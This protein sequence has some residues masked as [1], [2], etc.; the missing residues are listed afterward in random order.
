MSNI[1][2]QNTTWLSG[3][4]YSYVGVVQI[5]SN[6]TLT[7]EPGAIVNAN[8]I[9]TFGS[10]NAIGTLE[11]PI[12][13]NNVIFTFGSNSS[14]PGRLDVAFSIINGGTILPPTGNVSY[15]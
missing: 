5:A 11:N 9:Q 1:I 15:G 2:S 3:K 13:F 4:T 12:I 7:I 8:G 14:T 6:V 10:L